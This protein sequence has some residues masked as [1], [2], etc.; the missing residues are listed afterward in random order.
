MGA[1]RASDRKD[2]ISRYGRRLLRCGI[3]IPAR[4]ASDHSRQRRSGKRSHYFRCPKSRVIA[5]CFARAAKEP[6]GRT[7]ARKRDDHS[8]SARRC[9]SSE[10]T[11][12]YGN[13]LLQSATK[14]R[15][16]AEP[17]IVCHFLSPRFLKASLIDMAK[18]N[19]KG[20]C[21]NNPTIVLCL[22]HRRRT[23]EAD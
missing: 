9:A 21:F 16:P 8:A 18:N 17:I 20:R 11:L 3:S 2:S 4:T 13:S 23:F 6:R 22:F 5:A 10:C 15:R 1:V 12:N 14:G 7:R 19:S